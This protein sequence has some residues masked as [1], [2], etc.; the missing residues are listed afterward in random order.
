MADVRGFKPLAGPY[1]RPDASAYPNVWAAADT[2]RDVVLWEDRKWMN[3]V[4]GSTFDA[5]AA[6]LNSTPGSFW[7]DGVAMY[8]HPFGSTDPNADGKVYERSRN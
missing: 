2:Q 3:H 4:R 5:V 6:A 1:A 8:F 7:T